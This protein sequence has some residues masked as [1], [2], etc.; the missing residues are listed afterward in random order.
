MQ[1]RD[2]LN[3]IESFAPA[4]LQESYDNAGLIVGNP[5]DEIHSALI[6]VDVTEEVMQEALQ[7]KCNLIISHHPMVFSGMKRFTGRTLTERLVE[8]SIRERISVIALHTNLDNISEGVNKILSEKLGIRNP[9]ILRPLDNKL[10]K[11]VTFCPLSYSEKVRAAIFAAG[12]GHIGKYD[13]CSFNLTGKGSFRG[14][15]GANP[16]V[17]KINEV[18]FEEEIRIEV[19]YPEYLESQVIQALI[20]AHPY[21]EVA[22]DLYPLAN[23]LTTVGAG[24]IGELETAV[25]VVEFLQFVKK[26]LKLGSVKHTRDNG[27]PVRKVAVCG[28]SGAFL[29]KDAMNAG[30][31]IYLTGDIKYHDYFLPEN[32]M[33]L[34]DIGHFESEQYTK[35][36]I[37]TLLKKKFP[38]F[39]LLISEQ[40]ENPVKYL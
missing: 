12:A 23:T 22:Y 16:F 7:R 19:I 31:D 5:S 13:S 3:F 21:E 14:L 9:L 37:H 38:T 30:A 32:R 8:T 33:V 26:T 34:A 2:I 17:G 29:I 18:H 6:C 25:P 24:M 35:E 27:K 4:G 11:L 20:T 40:E 15:E 10:R 36:L 28:G 1:L 39:A